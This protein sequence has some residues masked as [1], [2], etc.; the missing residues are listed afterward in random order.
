MAKPTLLQMVQ[1]VLHTLDGDTVSSIS[2]TYEATQIAR[3]FRTTFRELAAEYN[4]GAHEELV[5]LIPLSDPDFP[6]HFQ[7]PENMHELKWLK[8]NKREVDVGDDSDLYQ[9]VN[10]LD[11]K[12]FLDYTNGRNSTDSNVQTVEYGTD[13]VK[14]YV[15]TDKHP[16]F[17]TSFDDEFIVCDSYFSDLDTSLQQSKVQALMSAMP[18]FTLTDAFVPDLPQNLFP[19]LYK[20]TEARCYALYKQTESPRLDR[21]ER[22]Q[23]I[24]AQRT[25]YSMTERQKF[26]GPN[27]GRR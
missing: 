19:L 13:L 10:Y 1:D 17:W 12:A 16:E 7:I 20:T 22:W 14:I 23:R 6:T 3:Q 9:D 5:S 24:R 18:P 25:R 2:D 21:E 26:I 8:Y 15:L 27:Y 11:P 4:L